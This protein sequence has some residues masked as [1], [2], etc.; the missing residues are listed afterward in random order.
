M[1]R[2]WTVRGGQ[3]GE[4]EELAL[5]EGMV[6]AGWEEVGDLSGC[7]SIADVGEVL[8]RDY[9]DEAPARVDNWK[10]QLWRFITMET[11]DLVVMPRKF[12]GVVAIGRLIG[13]YEYR[14]EAPP[15]FRHTRKVE[16]MRTQV[17]RAVIGGDLRD[18]IGAFLTVSEL[19]RRGAA[20]RVETLAQT[21][22]DPGY[23]GA[24][25]PPADPEAL[26]QDVRDEGTRQ[27]TARDLIGLWGWQ[28]RTGDAI[29]L[30]DRELSARGL[31]VVPHFTEVQLDGLITV[32]AQEA[33]P[34]GEAADDLAGTDLRHALATFNGED[35]SRHWRIGSLPFARNV[36]TVGFD[37]PLN[38]AITRMVQGDFSQLPVVNRNNVLRGVVTWESIA[39]AQMGHR[40]A[41]IQAALDPHPHTA[42]E[43]EELFVRI[44]DIQRRGFL[45]VTD[46]DNL[47]LGIL[48]AADLADQLKL[49]VEPFIL[50]GE[51][52]RRLRRLTDRLTIDELPEGSGVRKARAAGKRLT[53]GQYPEI[54]KD[55]T[56]WAKLGWPY[57][58]DELVRCVIA[59]K[60]YRNELAHWDMDAPETKT[61]ALTETKQLLKLLKA[62]DH[63]PRP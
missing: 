47:V 51:A 31:Q 44:D 32:S 61:D 43:Q 9:P 57:E 2:A 20:H 37:E 25:E 42:Q 7:E 58:Q 29:D 55:A 63:D 53:L 17:E 21:G 34:T 38:R 12:L 27:L 24:I 3:R 59:V 23:N 56:C 15:G 54:L 39:R 50:L 13:G 52:E 1:V 22:V 18:S 5:D 41:T 48:T 10:H 8:A 14:S 28:R 4:R 60:D 16:W 26:E 30:V 6:I 45:I 19:R 35:L 33:T 40:D 46:A 36:V 62:I 11:G 49:R